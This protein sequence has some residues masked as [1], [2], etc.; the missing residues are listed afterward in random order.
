MANFGKIYVELDNKLVNITD[1][2]K[3]FYEEFL[4]LMIN[5]KSIYDGA[6][7]GGVISEISDF[8]NENFWDL[9]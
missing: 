5:L 6:L 2:D 4:N 3:E 7:N 8:I 9:V 1:L